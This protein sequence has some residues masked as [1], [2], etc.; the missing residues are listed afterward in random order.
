VYRDVFKVVHPRTHHDQ[1]PAG[2]LNVR[3]RFIG[4][5]RC[6]HSFFLQK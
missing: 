4:I 2:R 3:L 6:F 1:L 5:M